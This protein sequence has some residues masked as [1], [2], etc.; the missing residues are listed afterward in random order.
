MPMLER[1]MTRHND[2]ISV[3]I[4]V[5]FWTIFA[6]CSTTSSQQ[7]LDSYQ[8]RESVLVKAVPDWRLSGSCGWVLYFD[9]YAPIYITRYQLILSIDTAVEKPKGKFKSDGIVIQL[10]CPDCFVTILFKSNEQIEK[11]IDMSGRYG[12]GYWRY[13]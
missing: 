2:L 8:Y 7:M 1:R 3:F 11:F 13:H 9:G 5:V 4:S 12:Y 10:D 6:S